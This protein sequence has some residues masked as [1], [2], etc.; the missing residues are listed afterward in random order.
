M[1]SYFNTWIA[2]VKRNGPKIGNRR[3]VLT[4][5][6]NPSRAKPWDAVVWANGA[7]VVGLVQPTP[8]D[9]RPPLCWFLS[10]HSNTLVSGI[11]TSE[12]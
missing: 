10:I 1:E 4:Q 11:F 2:N 6:C 7:Q 8:L 9:R 5:C 3:A 12:I